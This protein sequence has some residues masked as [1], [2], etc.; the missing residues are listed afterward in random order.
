MNNLLCPALSSFFEEER[1]REWE[2]T[3]KANP[4]PNT[5]GEARALPLS[6]RRSI[7]SQSGFTLVELLVV[8]VIIGILTSITLPALKGIGQA[9]LNA[10]ANRQLLDDLAFARLRAINDR[11]TVY[12]VFVPPYV[13]QKLDQARGDFQELRYVTNLLGGPYRG[14][15]LLAARTVGDQPGRGRR[16]YLSDWK[17]LPEGAL[18]APYKFDARLSIHPNDYLRGFAT[19]AFPFPDSSS[20]LFT[21]PYIAFNPYGQLA[22]QRDELIPLAKGHITFPRDDAGNF[23]RSAPDV[24]LIPPGQGTNTFQYVRI[25]WLTGRARIEPVI[26]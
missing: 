16:R 20:A 10:A 13:A 17:T 15:A 7:P 14:Y 23:I 8:M 22:S 19:N 9:N 4:L 24:Q 6:H 1:G 3:R 5:N 25:N 26:P 11:T 21:L 12:M 2:V 18:F